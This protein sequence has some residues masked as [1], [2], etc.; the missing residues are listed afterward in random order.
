MTRLIPLLVL[1]TVGC[2]SHRPVPMTL[3]PHPEP[4]G[5][6]FSEVLQTYHLGR[7]IDPTQAGIMH[8]RH[9]IFRVEAEARWDLR[10]GGHSGSI[11]RGS[12]PDAAY[13]PAPSGDA[14][15]AELNRQ[16]AFTEAVMAQA[17]QLA[18]SYDQLQPVITD[19][20]RVA[21]EHALVGATLR[22]LEER[23]LRLEEELRHLTPSP[24]VP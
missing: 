23:Q 13:S 1:C 8:E 18:R 11:S 15:T 9:A 19:M 6:R 5:V 14:I 3:R 20:A 16:Q 17:G 10:P 24:S 2:A 22:K 7:Q 12:P 21:R 4:T